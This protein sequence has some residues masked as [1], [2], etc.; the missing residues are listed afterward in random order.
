METSLINRHIGFWKRMSKEKVR[1]NYAN[2][3]GGTVVMGRRCVIRYCVY[4]APKPPDVLHH[5][6]GRAQDWSHTG[7][8]QY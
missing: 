4:D 6:A 1:S 2:N 8:D 3:K 5:V 7:T